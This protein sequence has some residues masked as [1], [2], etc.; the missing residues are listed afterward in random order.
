M[1]GVRGALAPGARPERQPRRRLRSAGSR[2][3]RARPAAV[4]VPGRASRRGRQSCLEPLAARLRARDESNAWWKSQLAAAFRA[5]A[6]RERITRRHVDH[7]AHQRAMARSGR[8]PHGVERDCACTRLGEV[9]TAA[10][11]GWRIQQPATLSRRDA[12]RAPRRTN[13]QHSIIARQPPSPR[14]PDQSR[15]FRD[16]PRRKDRQKAR[17]AVP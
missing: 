2:A 11:R 8:R 17:P 6:R 1:A 16:R 14:S 10:R 7:E 3:G 5:I 15:R 9:R 13:R 12:A 4:V